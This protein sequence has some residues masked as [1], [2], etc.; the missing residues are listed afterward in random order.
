[1]TAIRVCHSQSP[2]GRDTAQRAGPRGEAPGSEAERASTKHE[3]EAL[4]WL[5]WG[6]AS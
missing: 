4:L 2:G 6:K 3:Q 5:P 1:M